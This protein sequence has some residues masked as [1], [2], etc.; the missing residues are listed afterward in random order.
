MNFHQI[1]KFGFNSANSKTIQKGKENA[2][3]RLGQKW[4]KAQHY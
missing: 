4:S 3:Q 1:L 2:S